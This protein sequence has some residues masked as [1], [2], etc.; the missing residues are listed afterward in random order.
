[1]PKIF[2]ENHAFDTQTLLDKSD[3][4]NL[5]QNTQDILSFCKEWIKGK[6]SFTLHTSGSTGSPKPIQ[7]TRNQLLASVELTKNALSLSSKD[8]AFVGINTSFIAGKMMLVRSLEI[9]M[10]MYIFPPSANPLETF[11]KSNHY[12][13]N[14]TFTALVPYQVDAILSNPKTLEKLQKFRNI[15]IGGASISHSLTTRIKDNLPNVNVFHTYGMTETVSHIALKNISKNS[16]IFKVLK[17]ISI[18]VDERNCLK[19][20]G[21]ITQ[22]Q[23]IITNDCVELINNYSFKWLGRIDNVIN[24]GGIKLHLEEIE[25]KLELLFQNLTWKRFFLYGIPDEKLGHKLVLV[26]E[27]QKDN[28]KEEETLRQRIAQNLDSYKRPKEICFVEKFIETDTQK[29]DRK[30]TFEKLV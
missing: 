2:I 1:M 16:E 14:L 12:S 17:G 25:Q 10:D 19:I 28:W 29:I 6:E 21:D 20:K 23:W 7:I 8:V 11:L 13:Q 18:D 26:I 4:S 5:N 27:G 15:L 9:G 30:K 22:N 3:F 24:S